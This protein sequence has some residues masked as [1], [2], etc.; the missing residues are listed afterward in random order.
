M[1]GS[2]LNSFAFVTFLIICMRLPDCAV[3]RSVLKHIADAAGFCDNDGRRSSMLQ[4]ILLE[5][6][7]ESVNLSRNEAQQV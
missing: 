3:R 2:S 6:Y 5:F 4:V 1:P 7:A